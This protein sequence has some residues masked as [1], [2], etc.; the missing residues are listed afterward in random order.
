MMNALYTFG[1][2]ERF[3]KVTQVLDKL[4]P[5]SV[6]DLCFGDTYIA[7]HCKA[8]N[9]RWTGIDLNEYFVQYA[10][11]KGHHAI[12]QDL[13]SSQAFPKADVIVMVGSLYHFHS[14]VEELFGKMLEAGTSRKIILSEPIKN[15]SSQGGLIGAIAKRS[16]DA[17]K[18]DE[19]FRYNEASLLSMLEEKSRKLNFSYRIIQH[20]KKDIII[21][22]EKN[23]SDQP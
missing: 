15:L 14:R 5:G 4:H 3:K 2:T 12:Q 18:G 16:A 1:Y 10:V 11:S 6:L 13:L 8:N 7:D 20:Y 21:L 19:M 17:G 23:G 9:I 22:I